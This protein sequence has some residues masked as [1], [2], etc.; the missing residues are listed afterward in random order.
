[1]ELPVIIYTIIFK[2]KYFENIYLFIS[3]FE[4]FKLYKL[5]LVVYLLKFEF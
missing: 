3:T 1:M 4:I 5:Q 2:H